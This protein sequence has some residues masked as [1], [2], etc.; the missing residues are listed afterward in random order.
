MM[1]DLLNPG[2]QL[3]DPAELGRYRAKIYETWWT[4]G[5]DHRWVI[6]LL[7]NH[8]ICQETICSSNPNCERVVFGQLEFCERFVTGD[9]RRREDGPFQL[10]IFTNLKGKK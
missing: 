3:W 7:R 10:G 2:K 8:Q 1:D 4:S 5:D 6:P 9:R